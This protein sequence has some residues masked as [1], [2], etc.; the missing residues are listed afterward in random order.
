MKVKKTIWFR[1]LK[2]YRAGWPFGT[3]QES[4]FEKEVE[5]EMEM[6]WLNKPAI[7]LEIDGVTRYFVFVAE[8]TC[9]HYNE[10]LITP[11][12]LEDMR[13]PTKPKLF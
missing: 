7:S 4:L 8:T 11:I 6:D 3:E 13:E 5:L 2:R 12:K 9:W 1:G 10:V